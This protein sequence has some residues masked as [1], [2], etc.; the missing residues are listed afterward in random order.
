MYAIAC[1]LQ[2]H[3]L[4][5]PYAPSVLS[6]WCPQITQKEEPM[7]WHS[8]H[9]VGEDR[10]EKEDGMFIENLAREQARLG[11]IEPGQRFSLADMGKSIKA[12]FATA[13]AKNAV[14]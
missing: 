5:E 14:Q 8:V 10:M 7:Q 12:I 11:N 2:K 9:S 6:T 3:G 13:G 4:A 1:A